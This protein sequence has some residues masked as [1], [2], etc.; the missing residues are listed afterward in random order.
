MLNNQKPSGEKLGLGFNSFEASSSETKEIKF[1][2][3][4]K[5]VSPDGGPINMGVPLNVQAAPKS[6]MGPPLG[7]TPE[8]EKSVSFQKSIL[9]E[10]LR[11]GN[12]KFVPKGKNDE[13]F[14]MPI[15]NEPISNNIKNTPYYNAY[16]E[17][18][19]K[20]DR[21]V[22]AE[23]RGKKKPATAKQLKS[24]PAKEKS[25]KPA[26]APKL[27]VTQAKPAK[28]FL[29]KHSKMGK[30]LKNHKGK[31]S[32][33][34]INEDEPTQPE[35]EP[36]PEHQGEGDEHDVERAIQ[37]SLESFQAQSQAHV[38]GTNTDKKNSGGDTEI[39][40]IGEEHGDDVANMVNLKE[41]TDE[42][43]QGQAGLDHGKTLES[44]PL[45]EQV[46]IDEDQAEPNLGVSRVALAGP[47]LEPTHEEFIANVY[48]DVHESLKFPAD[49][50]KWVSI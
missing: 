15:P 50:H 48:L 13:V 31:S 44:R 33:Q 38:G 37:K 32:L 24:K 22:A 17:I 20:H 2:K 16:L 8:S 41:K 14:G 10:D 25:S 45:P 43:D 49:E 11:L 1:M 40:Q 21:K 7:T 9:E 12:L 27:K 29:A 42:L 19:T 28:P 23:K 36:K 4:Q 5:K 34:L 3:A 30:V 6:N 26:P 47:N 39:L 35:P 18:V 46:F